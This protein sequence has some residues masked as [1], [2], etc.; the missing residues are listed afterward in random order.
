MAGFDHFR[1]FSE[2]VG[3]DRNCVFV[4][5]SGFKRTHRGIAF[6]RA[7][8]RAEYHVVDWHHIGQVFAIGSWNIRVMPAVI[9]RRCDDVFQWA[10]LKI[11]VHMNVFIVK[12]VKDDDE[13]QR[14]GNLH[15]SEQQDIAGYHNHC[16]EEVNSIDCKGI[17]MRVRM[18]RRMCWPAPFCV[19]QAVVP[20]I[21]QITSRTPINSFRQSLWWFQRA[22]MARI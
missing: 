11:Q 21:H 6:S 5:N 2:G 22:K 1:P 14:L 19:H 12:N 10:M 16:F 7:V 9:D 17:Y 20:V 3:H 8:E 13:W 4:L 18:V 15:P